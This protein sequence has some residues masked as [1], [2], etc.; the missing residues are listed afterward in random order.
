MI[1]TIIGLWKWINSMPLIIHNLQQSFAFSTEWLIGHEDVQ[2]TS[3]SVTDVTLVPNFLPCLMT[4]KLPS[5]I[6]NGLCMYGEICS[7]TRRLFIYVIRWNVSCLRHGSSLCVYNRKT[8]HN[9][10]RYA[11][12]GVNM[13]LL[14]HFH[15]PLNS[16]FSD[17]SREMWLVVD[18]RAPMRQRRHAAAA[19]A[20]QDVR[21]ATTTTVRRSV[22]PSICGRPWSPQH[23]SW[24]LIVFGLCRR[25][26]KALCERRRPCGRTGGR[27]PARRCSLTAND[28]R[29]TANVTG[30]FDIK[31]TSSDL[32]ISGIS[33]R[34]LLHS[35]M[36]SRNQSDM[37][38]AC[39][40]FRQSRPGVFTGNIAIKSFT[41]ITVN[42][43]LSCS[44]NRPHI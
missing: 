27:P 35:V 3:E 22:G 26:R 15:Q 2:V 42:C 30:E 23:P 44:A 33:R 13:R 9:N 17:H 37:V 28:K 18:G 38:A 4:F 40:H 16:R 20:G 14:S 34:G 24:R 12:D 36:L 11:N 41:E 31:T 1:T 10:E 6:F 39:E 25:R 21:A 29:T 32:L 19:A 5:L 43:G 8:S 7:S